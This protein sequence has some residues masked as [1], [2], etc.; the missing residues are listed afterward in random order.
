MGAHK[1]IYCSERGS[2]RSAST[3][4]RLACGIAQWFQANAWLRHESGLALFPPVLSDAARE[5]CGQLAGV[6]IGALSFPCFS[7][8][9]FRFLPQLFT[10]P[11]VA[12]MNF[13]LKMAAPAGK[14]TL[15]RSTQK[16]LL[17]QGRRQPARP[18][19]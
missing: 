14:L 13:L 4:T 1:A 7:A 15:A 10:N 16:G 8:G 3:A 19:R 5:H 12:T 6:T 9:R 11:Q 18:A 2:K 17:A